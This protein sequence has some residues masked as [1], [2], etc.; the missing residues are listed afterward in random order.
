[1]NIVARLNLSVNSTQKQALLNLMGDYN[2]ACGDIS[3][4]AWETSTYG[5]FDL[6]HLCYKIIRSSYPTLKANHV[7]RAISRVSQ[8]YKVLNKNERKAYAKFKAGET[9]RW[10]RELRTFKWRNG[11]ELDA[12]LWGFLQ[13]GSISI[14]ASDRLKHIGWTCNQHNTDLMQAHTDSAILI[15][16]HGKFCLHVSC[17]VDEPHVRETDDYIGVDMGVVNI[18]TTSDGDNWNSEH[19]EIKRQWYAWRKAQLQRVD[20]DSAKRRLQKL[21][22]R[23]SRF[24]RDVDHCI[25]KDIV[26]NA[27]RTG[28]G[29]ALEDLSGIRKRVIRKA[30]RPKHHAWSFYRLR[31]YIEYKARLSGVLVIAV[32]PAY[33]SQRCNVCGYIDRANRQSQSEFVCRSCNHRSHADLNAALNIKDRADSTSLW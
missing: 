16:R 15:Y 33:T 23:E 14:A 24:K 9:G 27:E 26:A 11:V 22:G 32:D 8:S 29:I 17:E 21:S 1:M 10:Y 5:K 28:R 30:Q 25:S 3:Q 7:V 18:A 12:R 4:V 31:T 13:D 2:S 19:I 6:H 20:T